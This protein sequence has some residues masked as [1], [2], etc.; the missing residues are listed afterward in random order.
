MAKGKNK[1]HASFWFWMFALL[2][3]TLPCIGLIMAIVWAFWGEN[4]TRKNFFRAL[5]VWS[6]ILI[7][8]WLVLLAMGLFPALLKLLQYL[9]QQVK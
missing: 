4:E 7:T 5:I 2:V 8:V 9:P 6:L 1:N 3:M